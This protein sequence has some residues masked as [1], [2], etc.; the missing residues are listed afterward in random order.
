MRREIEADGGELVLQPLH[1]RPIRHL[2]QL[3]PA[4]HAVVAKKAVL[5]AA[6]GFVRRLRMADQRLDGGEGLGAVWVDRIEG[7]RLH[8][9]FEQPLVDRA[10]VEPLGEVVEILEGAVGLALLGQPQHGL[11]A[12]TLDGGQCIA[13]AA[14][15]LGVVST[16]N[17]A[18]ERLTSGGSSR[19]P[20]LSRSRR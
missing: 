7:A 9:A 18:V 2:G 14:L 6:L 8:Q 11:A 5:V 13:H 19:M 1:R 15:A 3:W 17:S 16:A 10:R 4:L 12:D 20:S